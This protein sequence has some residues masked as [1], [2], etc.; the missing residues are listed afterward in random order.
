MKNTVL[1]V[2]IFTVLVSNIFSQP[3]FRSGHILTLSV[4]GV[5]WSSSS[6]NVPQLINMYNIE[7]N[8]TGNNAVSLSI[9]NFPRNKR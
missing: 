4:G 7:N 1:M 8:Y 2:I 9:D 5:V 6:P 3:L